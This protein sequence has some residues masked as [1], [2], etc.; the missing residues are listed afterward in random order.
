MT[1]RRRIKKQINERV[2]NGFIFHV[3]YVARR[4]R[5]LTKRS[6]L[7]RAL[8]INSA[9]T[10]ECRCVHVFRA[11]KRGAGKYYGATFDN[12]TRLSCVYTM[13][14]RRGGCLRFW[15]CICSC[16]T[17]AHPLA[18]VGWGTCSFP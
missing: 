14:V 10:R 15:C 7:P 6:T 11:D 13:V 3:L 9:R 4:F 8:H 16:A 1:S 5:R 18:L 17:D 2:T 12:H